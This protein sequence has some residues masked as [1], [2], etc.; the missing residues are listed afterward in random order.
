ML[1]CLSSAKI[2]FCFILLITI[3]NIKFIL[4]ICLAFLGRKWQ[5]A[6]QIYFITD[7]LESHIFLGAENEF[8][9]WVIETNNAR[10]IREIELVMYYNDVDC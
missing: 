10:V 7:L 8:Y 5:K 9:S 2:I 3:I 4:I 1:S 6:W